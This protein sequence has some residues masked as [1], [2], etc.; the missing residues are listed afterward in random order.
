MQYSLAEDGVCGH[1]GG[2][3]FQLL[4]ADGS[5]RAWGGYGYR[6]E[7]V[8]LPNTGF[9]AIAAGGW[10]SLGLKADGSITAWGNNEFGQCDVPSPNTGFVAISA[11]AHHS[12]G[13]KADGSIVAWGYN[14]G[15]HGE[16]SGQCIVPSPNSGFVAIAAGYW[17]SLGL[18]SDGSIVAWGVPTGAIPSP[19]TGYIAIAAG[20]YYNLGHHRDGFD[21]DGIADR[22][23]NCPRAS[24]PDQ[25]YRQGRIRRCHATIVRCI[26]FEPGRHGWG[27]DG[28]CAR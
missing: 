22:L 24:N 2:S 7:T 12:L 4:K 14:K 8:P 3:C 20:A 5:I 15:E 17:H 1:F 9:V 16:D 21:E 27:R 28:G 13:L 26:Q 18:K 6:Q 10:H 19:N 11:G 23:D 25:G